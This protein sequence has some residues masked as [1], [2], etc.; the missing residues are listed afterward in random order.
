MRSRLVVPALVVACA[1]GA[2][3]IAFAQTNT[4]AQP[5]VESAT[6]ARVK[7]H[8]RERTTLRPSTTTGMSRGTPGAR[9]NFYKEPSN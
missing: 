9:H 4:A 3:D 1:L 6:A 7:A 2:T 5:A 8:H